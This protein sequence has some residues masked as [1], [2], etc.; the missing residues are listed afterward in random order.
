VKTSFVFYEEFCSA[1]ISVVHIDILHSQPLTHPEMLI[2]TFTKD[3][4]ESTEVSSYMHMPIISLHG[5]I[6]GGE[7]KTL[8]K[9][10]YYF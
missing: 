4:L 6:T 9:I 2:G 5:E 8:F 10:K 1:P 7:L 3:F